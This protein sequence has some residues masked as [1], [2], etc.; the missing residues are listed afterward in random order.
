MFD[1]EVETTRRTPTLI[2]MLT[3]TLTL[4]LSLTLAQPPLSLAGCREAAEPGY[5]RLL[6]KL[7]LTL[8]LILT[9]TLEQSLSYATTNHTNP[10]HQGGRPSVVGD[11]APVGGGGALA[12][13]RRSAAARQGTYRVP[14]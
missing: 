13:I 5:F 12:R 4:T 9:L 1:Y 2:L 14:G 11:A 6:E 8:T 10:F 7:T 3:L